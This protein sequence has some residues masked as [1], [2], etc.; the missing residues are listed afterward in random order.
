MIE[1]EEHLKHIEAKREAIGK[2]G[3]VDN[4]NALLAYDA[5]LAAEATVLKFMIDNRPEKP[6]NEYD[7]NASETLQVADPKVKPLK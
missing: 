2:V 7:G 4:H 1:L 5:I 3:Q 6:T